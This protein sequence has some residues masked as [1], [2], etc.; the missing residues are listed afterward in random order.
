MAVRFHRRRRSC[1]AMVWAALVACWL[2][3]TGEAPPDPAPE[4]TIEPFAFGPPGP[5]TFAGRPSAPQQ[6][7][8]VQSADTP[9]PKPD[10]TELP[11]PTTAMP[12]GTLLLSSFE[13]KDREPGMLLREIARQSVLLV[14]REDLGQRTRD[15][16]LREFALS[17]EGTKWPLE[18]Q[19]ADNAGWVEIELIR[20]EGETAHVLWSKSLRL[21]P[22][23]ILEQ[24]AEKIPAA[25]RS[26]LVP[27]LKKQGFEG[28]PNP[29]AA[30]GDAPENTATLLGEMTFTSQFHAV[31]QVHRALRTQGETPDRLAALS[32]AMPTWAC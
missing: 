23:Q 16:A 2:G 28:K 15:V 11:W 17:R 6:P 14:A 26:E 12:E 10:P 9:K 4:P 19:V 21:E 3:C 27:L 13:P 7:S 25:I 1:E 5:G 29:V 20:R 22:E 30:T 24:A 31:R 32:K 8:V 18:V